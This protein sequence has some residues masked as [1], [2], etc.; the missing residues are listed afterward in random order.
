MKC[1]LQELLEF[2]CKTSCSDALGLRCFAVSSPGI[3]MGGK[4]KQP[5]KLS[6]GRRCWIPRTVIL[7]DTSLNGTFVN[8]TLVGKG[9]ETTVPN[10]ASNGECDKVYLLYSFDFYCNRIQCPCPLMP[11]LLGMV[12]CCWV[13]RC[14]GHKRLYCILWLSWLDM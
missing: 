3:I 10:G 11:G 2:C 8:G 7:A 1:R 12:L 5:P 13:C 6:L 9:N 14:V 4:K